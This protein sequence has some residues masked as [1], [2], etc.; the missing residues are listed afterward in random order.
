MTFKLAVAIV[1][2]AA[3]FSPAHATD[4]LA[5]PPP[6]SFKD[7]PF[8]APRPIWVG[9]YI[10]A[11]AGAGWNNADITDAYFYQGD[12]TSKFR[13]T[14]LGPISGVQAG[15]NIVRGN[16]MY[17]LEVDVGYFGLK[18]EKKLTL[19]PTTSYWLKG[20][21]ETSGDVYSDMTARVGYAWDR[22]LLYVK[23]GTAV[24]DGEVKASYLG[25]NHTATPHSFDFDNG[26]TLW[27][28]TLGAGVEYQFYPQ[29]SLKAEYR[30]FD[31]HDLSYS[32]NA[33]YQ[34]G[35]C[36]TTLKGNADAAMSADTVTLGF[37][38]YLN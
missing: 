6:S 17:G 26:D 1:G 12:P 20:S 36:N 2:A 19:I 10:G 5:P 25:A 3:I 9:P 23:G 35:C 4:L 27:G 32:H 33:T 15:Y 30:H 22:A 34:A 14:G 38:R 31:F 28:W 7:I 21:Y 8:V 18:T 29:W 16:F 24:L 11:H 13:A 37:N